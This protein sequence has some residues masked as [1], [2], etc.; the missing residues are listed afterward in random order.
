V[1]QPARSLQSTGLHHAALPAL[2]RRRPSGIRAGLIEMS[3]AGLS[4]E[5]PYLPKPE[6]SGKQRHCIECS[7]NSPMRL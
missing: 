7:D 2:R 4:C 6:K 1:R 5:N 3:V